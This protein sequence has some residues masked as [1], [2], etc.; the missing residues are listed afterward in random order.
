MNPVY[1]VGS[2][3]SY[4]AVQRSLWGKENRF[5]PGTVIHHLIPF[6][7]CFL[8]WL[9]EKESIKDL[10]KAIGAK[11]MLKY[12]LRF[13]TNIEKLIEESSAALSEE[14]LSTFTGL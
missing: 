12:R 13:Y 8:Y 4:H 5:I 11:N 7:E 10:K 1:I 2:L 6:K 3:Q 14:Q 9:P